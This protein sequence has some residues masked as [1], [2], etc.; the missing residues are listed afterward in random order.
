MTGTGRAWLAKAAEDAE[1]GAGMAGFIVA[2]HRRAVHAISGTVG[3]LGRRNDHSVGVVDLFVE[4]L[5]VVR[6]G[7]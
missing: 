6:A 7:I 1:A 3:G 5:D 2:I 4:Q